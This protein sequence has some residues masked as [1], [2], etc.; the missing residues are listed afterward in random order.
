MTATERLRTARPAL[1]VGILGVFLSAMGSWRPSLWYD[2]AATVSAIHRPLSAMTDLLARTDAVHALYYLCMHVWTKV[3]GLSEFSLRFPSALAV[4]VA[5]GLL[6]VLGERLWDTRFG[7]LAGLVLLCLPRTTWAGS[8]ARSYAG[9]IALAIAMTLVLLIALDVDSAPR[10]RRWGWWVAYVF[11]CVVGVVWFFFTITLLAAHL[12]IVLVRVRA[13]ADRR[14]SVSTAG[15][16]VVSAIVV[17]VIVAPFARVVVSQRGQISWVEQMTPRMLGN[18]ARYE[19]FDGA[20]VFLV[21]ASVVAVLGIVAAV[22]GA[23]GRWSI[24]VVG[25]LWM[26]VPAALVF[27]F[28]WV[29]DAVYTP[30]YLVFTAG[31]VALILAWAVRQLARDRIWAAALLVVVLAA[32]AA[33]S[34]LADRSPYGRLGGTDFSEA[35]DFIGD[36]ARPGDCVAFSAQPTWSPVSQRVI[37][38]AKPDDFVG[39]RDVGPSVD[40]IRADS[41]WDGDKPVTAYRHFAEKCSV[42]WVI[43]D[44]DRDRGYVTYPGATAYWVFSPSHFTST[45]LYQQLSASGLRLVRQV[46]FNNSQV[47][48]MRR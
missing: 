9:T 10:R 29:V 35:A 1:A 32:A 23:R 12:M 18:Y 40:A 25:V 46:P 5:A 3:F 43:A 16:F 27:V 44:K 41:L 20:T 22:V 33:P 42:M 6:V 24:F 4:G 39:L 47:V 36:N 48:E 45:P 26:A 28:S 7:V 21:I 2:E 13:H 37:L 38:R 15:A 30:R 31:G 17:C 19:F 11:V 14:L 34:Y 8:E